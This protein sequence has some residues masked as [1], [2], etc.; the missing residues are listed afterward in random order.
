MSKNRELQIAADL[1]FGNR[2]PTSRDAI[3]SGVL[4]KSSIVSGASVCAYS[5]AVHACVARGSSP[6]Y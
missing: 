4:V 3:L 5:D 6:R 2:M 1:Q